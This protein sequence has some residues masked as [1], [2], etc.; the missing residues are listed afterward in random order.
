M[1]AAGAT[2]RQSLCAGVALSLGAAGL[3][4]IGWGRA[5]GWDASNTVGRFVAT[6]SL[7]DPFRRQVSFN[8]Q[9]L[10]SALEHLVYSATGSR[11]ERVLRVLPIVF[12]AA[13]VGFLASVVARRLGVLAGAVA[14]IAV[15]VNPLS[16]LEFRE[17]R[18]Y[19]LLVFTTVVGTWLLFRLKDEPRQP[20]RVVG[21]Y[22]AT[23]AAGIATHLYGLAVLTTHAVIVTRDRGDLRRWLP[24]W[25]AAALAGLAPAAIPVT[26][27][28]T[29]HQ[30]R[31]FRPL[32][33]L[34]VAYDLIG[35][36]PLAFAALAPLVVAG[37]WHL[38]RRPW[39]PATVL[40][41][42][43]M[44][45]V[46]WLAGPEFLYSRF[47]I[48]LLPGVGVLAA[49]T[50]ARR[51]ALAVLVV[52]GTAAQML[53]SLPHLREDRFPNRVAAEVITRAKL[54]GSR[55]CAIRSTATTLAAYTKDVM[56]VRDPTQLDSCDVVVVA[57]GPFDAGLVRAAS[58]RFPHSLLLPAAQPGVAFSRAPLALAP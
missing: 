19:S 8:N 11:D 28:L 36:Q 52:V 27:A 14:G 45:V 9:V 7:L 37:L 25:L 1:R 23:M 12:G 48:W 30:F 57:E 10:F 21:A 35:G 47:F 51:P 34:R 55:P 40:A 58:H 29:R 16:F 31:T 22:V 24:R 42:L 50:V 41:V 2:P 39:L 56:I 44:V 6:P 46:V 33:P 49:V 53:T 13:A 26:S 43:A 38:R 15:A 54:S 4:C 3:Y 5:Y 18:G 17:V 32:F 20:R